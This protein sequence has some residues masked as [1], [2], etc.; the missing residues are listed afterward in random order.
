[1]I[2]SSALSESWNF[3]IQRVD[4][5]LESHLTRTD[6]NLES[7]SLQRAMRYATLGGGKRFRAALVYATGQGFGA[8][9]KNLDLPA[10]AV[11]LIHA[12]S[13]V[14][15]DLPA[16]D[17]DELRR[18]KPSCHIAFNEATAI[19]AGDA[20]Q[21]LGF[22]ILA[23]KSSTCSVD[24][25]LEMIS[26]LAQ[27]TG[28]FGMAGGQAIDL[29]A[30]KSVYSKAILK[31]MHRMKTGAL[32][33]ASIQLGA[34]AAGVKDPKLLET[35]RQ[36]GLTLGL[37]F[38]ITDDIL[39]DT[40]KT[41]VLGKIQGSDRKKN[42]PTFLTVLG[43]STARRAAREYKKLAL[44]TLATL[45]MNVELLLKLTEFVTSRQH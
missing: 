40:E 20:L 6:S 25:Q 16:M 37:A 27:A 10:C 21:S 13:L 11:E 17:N 36:Y 31:Q 14:H 15:D 35:L 33:A 5:C 12:F 44:Q 24:T 9:V 3:W 39:D 45:P 22:E 2:R 38:Q 42:K 7:V 8:D 43:E 34:L 32:I 41:E 30:G 28:A 29:S 19:L 1:M 18:G 23:C 4:K 26:V